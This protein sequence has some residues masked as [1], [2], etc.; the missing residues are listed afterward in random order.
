[1][2]TR[3]PEIYPTTATGHCVTPP[4]Q[5]RE[6]DLERRASAAKTPTAGMAPVS[7]RTRRGQDGARRR[8]RWPVLRS[9][10]LRP[11]SRGSA[12]PVPT[13]LRHA[14]VSAASLSCGRGERA[15]P[16]MWVSPSG[17]RHSGPQAVH[18][19]PPSRG[20]RTL[21]T[22][23]HHPRRYD[24]TRIANSRWERRILRRRAE[25]CR[26]VGLSALLAAV[27]GMPRAAAPQEAVSPIPDRSAWGTPGLNRIALY[28]TPDLAPAG[29]TAFLRWDPSPFGVSVTR[30][31]SQRYRLDLEIEGLPS[32]GPS[33]STGTGSP[34]RPRRSW[35]RWSGSARWE[36]EPLRA[37]DR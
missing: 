3:I 14:N 8:R 37:S 34:G 12:K 33:A 23:A 32:P 4:E 16:I 35:T 1:M 13:T 26:I 19:R 22:P 27:L 18:C 31:G 15:D 30:D 6:D 11:A 9:A 25:S 2:K 28:P 29:G 36:T 17:A 21:P 7:A 24:T 20:A 5:K 10:G